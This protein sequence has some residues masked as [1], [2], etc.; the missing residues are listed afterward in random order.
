MSTSPQRARTPLYK[1]ILL[2]NPHV[3]KSNLLLRLNT[4]K[5]SDE[6]SNT[7]GIE[8]VTKTMTIG[9]ESVKAQIWDTA[10]QERFKT[11]TTAYYRGA[12][13]ILLA[14]DVTNRQTF[15][16]VKNWMRQIEMHA[17]E[18]VSRNRL[19]PLSKKERGKNWP[20]H[21]IPL[22]HAPPLVRFGSPQERKQDH[23][24]Q[25]MRRLSRE[26]GGVEGGRRGARGAVR[27][28]VF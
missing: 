9:E 15:E 17:A 19:H 27:G 8:F 16:N 24:R 20:L 18:Y 2:G 25:Q 6:N 21:I 11:I 12:M 13:G 1:L 4:G 7:I 10:G 23:H 3:G 14:Y 5:F 28:S 22:T 26:P